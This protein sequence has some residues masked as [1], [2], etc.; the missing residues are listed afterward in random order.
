M[1]GGC[2]G[3]NLHF[4][5]RHVAQVVVVD[6]GLYFLGVSHFK[7]APHSSAHNPHIAQYDTAAVQEYQIRL[8]IANPLNLSF[9]ISNGLDGATH[10]ANVVLM[11][12][13]QYQHQFKL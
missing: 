11:I 3:E 2:G 10:F 7:F 12:A 4:A 8:G 5:L 1:F 9:D 13:C 6:R